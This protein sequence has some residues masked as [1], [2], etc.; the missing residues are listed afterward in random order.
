MFD[1]GRVDFAD[2]GHKFFT[3]EIVAVLTILVE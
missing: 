1:L 3:F 2:I